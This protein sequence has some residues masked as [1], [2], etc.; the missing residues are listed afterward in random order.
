MFLVGVGTGT[1]SNFGPMLA[2]LFPTQVRN[3]GMSTILN[4]SRGAQFGAPVLIALLEPRFGLAAG[5]GL[6]AGFATLA[7][8]L[9]WTLP[10][11]QA[12]KLE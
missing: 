5:I 12:R 9:V 1:W 3:T 7:A 8:L 6:A 10:E 4:V 2:E 11:T